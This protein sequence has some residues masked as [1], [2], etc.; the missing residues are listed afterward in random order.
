MNDIMD[1]ASDRNYRLNV[2]FQYP[3]QPSYIDAGKNTY[4]IHWL[5]LA[6]QYL[7]R[8]GYKGEPVVLLASKDYP[9][10]YNSALVM[11]QELQAVGINAQLNV[12]DW[13]TSVQLAANTTSGWNFFYTGWGTPTELGPNDT[14]LNRVG[15]T[16]TYKPKGGAEDTKM[17]A[18]WNDMNA[19][20]TAEER[21]QAFA[22]M[23]EYALDQVYA[24]PFGSFTKVQGVVAQRAGLRAVPYP[25]NGQCVVEPVTQMAA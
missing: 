18:L 17:V 23:Q 9:P 11:Q 6:K 5:V 2:G 13:P 20:P 14:M 3:N 4:N 15:A 22:K 12:V 7:M 16:A 19:L 24:L 8:S 10:M 21:K 1:E 25:A